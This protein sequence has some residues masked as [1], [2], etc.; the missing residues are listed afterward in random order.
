MRFNC[1]DIVTTVTDEATSRFGGKFSEDKE[2]KA[3]LASF[4]NMIDVLVNELEGEAIEAEVN[5]NTREIT[6]ALDCRE[7]QI[8]S[9]GDGVIFDLLEASNAFIVSP[10]DA[11]DGTV[12]IGFVT[13]GIW[14]QTD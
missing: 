3:R 7:F 4:C 6:I 13:D 1:Y 8:E 2:Q 5:E 14:T 11:E 9:G 10:A 12:K